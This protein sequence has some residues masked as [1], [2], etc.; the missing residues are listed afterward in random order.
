MKKCNGIKLNGL[1]CNNSVKFGK[2]CRFH[3]NQCKEIH[4]GLNSKFRNK[5]GTQMTVEERKLKYSKNQIN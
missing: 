2:Y 1:K 5:D 3:L 4:A